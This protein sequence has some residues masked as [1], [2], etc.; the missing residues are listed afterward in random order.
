MTDLRLD[1]LT[2]WLEYFFDDANFVIT[3][4]SDDASFRRY[5]RVERDNNTFIAMDAP[6]EKEDNASFVK[7]ATLLRDNNLHAPKVIE[8]NL[9]Q[10]FLLLEDLGNTTFL[11]ALNND[12]CINLYKKAIDE[13]IKIQKID[14]QNTNLPLYND[15]LLKNEMQLFIDWYLPLRKA[16]PSPL[17]LTDIFQSLSDNALNSPQVFVHRDYHARNL[18]VIK[19]ELAIIDFQDAVIG[20]NTY[21]LCSLL[22]DAYI[23]LSANNIQILLNYYYT[24]SNID[25][26]FSQFK[27]QF[28]L[29]GLQRHLKILG[30][31]K[32]LSKRDGKHQYLDDIPLVKK[33]ILQIADKYLEFS[34]LR[35]I[36]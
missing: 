33:Y 26:E 14:Y 6:P 13:L 10:G 16:R 22:K 20:S 17:L 4:A 1:L 23:E 11:Q 12:N 2:D 36:L 18:M 27:K 32:R 31:F 28:E 3:K 8:A 34:A 9:T 35:G 7:I 24:K 15:T 29:M 30:I 5:F 21:D 19:D 25:I